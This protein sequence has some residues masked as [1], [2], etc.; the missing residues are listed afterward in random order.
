MEYPLPRWIAHRGGGALAPE[1]TLA[2]IRLAARLG[3]RAVEF[4]VMLTK[5][6]IPVLFHDETLERTTDG[7]GRLADRL[8]SEIASLD[9]GGRFHPAWRGEAVPCLEDALKICAHLGLAV[10]LEIKPV[11]GFEVDTGRLAGRL[12]QRNWP[13]G[14]LLFS[15]FAADALLAAARE[16]PAFPRALLVGRAPA[17]CLERLAAVGASALHF[18]AGELTETDR[19]ALQQEGIP[20]AAYTVNELAMAELCWQQGCAALFTDRLDGFALDE[21]GAG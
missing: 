4:D 20:F 13:G 14:Q 1:N 12:V 6:G 10:N 5:D 7:E 9:A 2:G 18:R 21:Q 11:A 8:W 15:S 17:N 16:A 19:K 3:F